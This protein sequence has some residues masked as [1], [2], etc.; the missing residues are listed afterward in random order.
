MSSVFIHESCK[1]FDVCQGALVM[2]SAVLHY[3][4]HYRH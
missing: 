1:K 3:M 2:A 4:C